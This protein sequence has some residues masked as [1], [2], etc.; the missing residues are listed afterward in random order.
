MTIRDRYLDNPNP[1][2]GKV[3]SIMYYDHNGDFCGV[4]NGVDFQD[5][6]R[7]SVV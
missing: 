4:E 5:R 1:G 6:D 3:S 7:K 2:S